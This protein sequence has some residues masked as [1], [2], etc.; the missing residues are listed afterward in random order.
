MHNGET[1]P[2]PHDLLWIDRALLVPIGKKETVPDWVIKGSGPVVVRRDQ[3]SPGWVAVGVRGERRAN[4]FPAFAPLT[5]I[6]WCVTPFDLAEQCA[7]MKAGDR[8]GY[9]ALRALERV[10]S[11]LESL[12]L[13]WGITGSVGYELASGERQISMQSDLD[14]IIAR[15]EQLDKSKA[16]S[17]VSFLERQQCRVDVQLETGWGAVALAE[18]ANASGKVLLKTNSGPQLVENPWM[19]HKQGA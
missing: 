12:N 16:R 4:R 8:K 7:W 5:G 17:L 1:E 2:A 14:L 6:R 3:P 9:P 19:A 13:S 18:W 11:H 10:A 15:P